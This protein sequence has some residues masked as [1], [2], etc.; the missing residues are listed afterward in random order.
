M[1]L[2]IFLTVFISLVCI[3]LMILVKILDY[4]IIE[5]TAL[6]NTLNEWACNHNK[7]TKRLLKD[8]ETSYYSNL[9]PEVSD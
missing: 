9:K 8:L 3:A 7:L 2:E 4:R 1:F 5:L 6:I